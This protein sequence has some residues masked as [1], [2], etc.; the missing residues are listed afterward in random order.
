MI[1][2]I[3]GGAILSIP[4]AIVTYY[5][6]VALKPDENTEYIILDKKKVLKGTALICALSLLTFTVIVPAIAYVL[7][8]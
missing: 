5:A 6:L 8:G 2:L 7:G 4:M 1:E 3:I